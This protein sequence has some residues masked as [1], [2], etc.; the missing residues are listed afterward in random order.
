MP[1][2]CDDGTGSEKRNVTLL[3]VRAGARRSGSAAG[4]AVGAAW[5]QTKPSGTTRPERGLGAGTRDR[6]DAASAATSAELA[7]GAACGAPRS[8]PCAVA[9]WC[10]CK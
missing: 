4:A 6:A 7:R 10:A 5:Q 8:P 2:A 3:P 1:N 9:A